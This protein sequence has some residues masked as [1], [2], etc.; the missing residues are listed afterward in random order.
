[1]AP[2]GSGTVDPE[3]RYAPG[4]DGNG[5]FLWLSEYAPP[6]G[7]KNVPSGG[8]CVSAF[9]FVRRGKKILLG[10]IRPHSDWERLAGLDAE[11]QEK[12]GKGYNIPSR[13]LKFGED[14]LHAARHIGEKILA[15]PNIRCTGP[16]VEVEHW[17]LG[18]LAYGPPER[19]VLWH[20]DIWFLFDA[21]VPSSLEIKT[22][23]WFRELEWH[24]PEQVAKS[25]YTRGHEDVVARWMQPQR[26]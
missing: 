9:V 4:M 23:P 25:A 2:V 26:A 20:Y 11:R 1:M 8:M 19:K 18:D 24:D 12:H 13:Q 14:P 6:A 3:V 10:K 7:F 21:E 22:P 17:Q 16:R 15:I 5:P